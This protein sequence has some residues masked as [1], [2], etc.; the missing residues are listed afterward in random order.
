MGVCPPFHRISLCEVK[1]FLSEY[2]FRMV[3][4]TNLLVIVY[5]LC[6]VIFVFSLIVFC[7]TLSSKITCIIFFLPHP[8]QHGSVLNL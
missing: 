3:K 8:V 7:Q 2:K 6:T 1:F 4:N 5:Q